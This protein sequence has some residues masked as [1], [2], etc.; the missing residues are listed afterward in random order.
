MCTK[1]D[2]AVKIEVCITMINLYKRNL[3]PNKPIQR[4]ESTMTTDEIQDK[5]NVELKKLE[6]FENDY[7]EYFI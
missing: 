6:Q 2:I 3:P 5:L 1:D 4:F 7:P